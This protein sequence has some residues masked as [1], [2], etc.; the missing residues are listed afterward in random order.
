MYALLAVDILPERSLRNPHL[1]TELLGLVVALRL[2]LH[3]SDGNRVGLTGLL[4]KGCTAHLQVKG[5]NQNDYLVVSQGL[6]VLGG[7]ALCVADQLTLGLGHAGADLLAAL[8][9][10]PVLPVPAHLLL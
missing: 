6:G 5:G 10:A 4:I 3:L 2:G 1:L 8:G 7:G 9:A